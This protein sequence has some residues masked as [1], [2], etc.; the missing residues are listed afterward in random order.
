MLYVVSTVIPGEPQPRLRASGDL[1]FIAGLLRVAPEPAQ[2]RVR[3]KLFAF[4][5]TRHRASSQSRGSHGEPVAV[6]GMPNRGGIA[7]LRQKAHPLG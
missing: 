1:Y 7:R 2:M 6:G 5:Q 4:G 3:M